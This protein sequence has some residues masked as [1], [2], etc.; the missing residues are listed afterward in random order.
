VHATELHPQSL[1]N[2]YFL[3]VLQQNLDTRITAVA[4]S[5]ESKITGSGQEDKYVIAGCL[6][7]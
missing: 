2:K 7:L 6:R 1:P 4:K 5:E 3:S